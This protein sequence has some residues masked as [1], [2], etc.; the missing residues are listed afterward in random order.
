[1]ARK[2][3]EIEKTYL[4]T[5]NKELMSL[6]SAVPD[7]KILEI[8]SDYALGDWVRIIEKREAEE[9]R[10]AL[11]LNPFAPLRS[12]E[13][14]M[15]CFQRLMIDGLAD[16]IEA[17]AGPHRDEARYLTTKEVARPNAFSFWKRVSLLEGPILGGDFSLIPY[18][19]PEHSL[20]SLENKANDANVAAL[21][22]HACDFLEPLHSR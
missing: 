16:G 3:R 6:L 8:K 4:V 2:C 1:L 21:F 20:L 5:D 12:E 10:M 9:I 17:V 11:V 18:V 14:I 13:N 7:L 22:S 15:E 19:V